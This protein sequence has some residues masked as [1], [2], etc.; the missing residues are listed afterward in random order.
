[1]SVEPESASL[2]ERL[3]SR[4]YLLQPKIIDD[5]RVQDFVDHVNLNIINDSFRS[6]TNNINRGLRRN[7]G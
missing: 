6:E 4:P 2:I 5:K 3:D 1:M 7:D